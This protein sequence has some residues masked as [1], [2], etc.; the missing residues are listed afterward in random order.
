MA[1]LPA[2]AQRIIY[3]RHALVLPRREMISQVRFGELVGAEDEEQGG[4][5]YVPSTVKRWEEGAKPGASAI[6][7][8]VNL[9]RKAGLEWV[10]TDSLLY[11][12]GWPA[13]PP[14]QTVIG[15]P[16][17]SPQPVPKRKAALDDPIPE[18]RERPSAARKK[19]GA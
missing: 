16:A 19:K 15:A 1:E 4:E 2:L 9:A 12:D 6:R 17:V 13:D 10:T 3:L 7:A 11:G 18:P 8:M 5:P 14:P